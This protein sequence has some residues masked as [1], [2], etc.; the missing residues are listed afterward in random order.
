MSLKKTLLTRVVGWRRPAVP[1][2]EAPEPETPEA[3]APTAKDDW[4]KALDELADT[5]DTPDTEEKPPL[6]DPARTGRNHPP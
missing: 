1:E 6:Q 4:D 5:A 3:K 2:P